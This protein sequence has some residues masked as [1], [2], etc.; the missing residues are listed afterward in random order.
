MNNKF[1][2][3]IYIAIFSEKISLILLLKK[4]QIHYGTEDNC[5]PFSSS[6]VWKRHENTGGCVCQASHHNTSPRGIGYH[7]NNNKKQASVSMAHP[8]H[9]A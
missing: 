4:F 9:V 3:I 1:T 8:R 6:S 5:Y 2:L 7:I